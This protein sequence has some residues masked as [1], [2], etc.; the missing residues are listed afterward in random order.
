MPESFQA[1]FLLGNMF[2]FLSIS[3][4]YEKENRN[5]NFNFK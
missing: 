4:L 3:K 1:F 5:V 2:L